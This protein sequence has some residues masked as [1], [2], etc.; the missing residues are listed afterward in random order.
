MVLVVLDHVARRRGQF[1]DQSRCSQKYGGSHGVE[2]GHL[3][4]ADA[5]RARL[6]DIWDDPS[7]VVQE[8]H[9]PL[10]RMRRAATGSRS[11]APEFQ[12][13]ARWH[14]HSHQRIGEIV[15]GQRT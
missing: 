5:W 12:R 15:R 2:L 13:H 6:V 14:L 11:G 9:E 8:F 3:T 7:W 10:V 4:A 1:L